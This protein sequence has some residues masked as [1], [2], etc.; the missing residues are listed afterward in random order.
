MSDT[1]L[2]LPPRTAE[3]F[4]GWL[5][6]RVARYLELPES[7]VDPDLS[8]SD[9]GLDSVFAFSL[10]GDIEDAFGLTIEPQD[11]WDHDTISGLMAFLAQTVTAPPS[12]G[13][14]R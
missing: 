13:T 6:E 7:V 12:P 9:H 4:Q 14:K 1:D 3:D 5:V 2:T 8:L 10:C 11:V